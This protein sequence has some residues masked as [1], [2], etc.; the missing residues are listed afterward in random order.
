MRGRRSVV[1]GR[2]EAMEARGAKAW[3]P[4]SRTRPVT[5][6]L[7]AYALMTTS[8]AFGAVRDISRFED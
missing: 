1:L 4:D 2:C 7:R 8:A 5:Q 6:A 3:K